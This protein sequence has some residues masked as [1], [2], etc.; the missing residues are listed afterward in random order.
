MRAGDE[1]AERV[2]AET[3][4]R[5]SL[6]ASH[7]ERRVPR[8]VVAARLSETAACRRLDQVSVKPLDVRNLLR[9]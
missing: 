3:R 9:R 4:E 2:D 1:L 8:L 6:L 5:L 7:G